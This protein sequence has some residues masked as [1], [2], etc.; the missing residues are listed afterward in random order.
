[1]IAYI[2]LSCS[3]IAYLYSYL[4]NVCLYYF[5]H[6]SYSVA[7][8]VVFCLFLGVHFKLA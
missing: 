2:C 6:V 8:H 3:L 1:M 7:I 5:R 4:H